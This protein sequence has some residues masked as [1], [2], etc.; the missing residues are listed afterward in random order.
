MPPFDNSVFVPSLLATGGYTQ[1]APLKIWLNQ[2]YATNYW[3]IS[4]LR[5]NPDNIPVKIYT[6]SDKMSSPV[7]QAGD[8]VELEP[9]RDS[10][11]G[12]EYVEWALGF[13]AKHGIDVFVPMRGMAGIAGRVKDF[14]AL[15]TRVLVSP[16]DAVILLDDKDLAYKSARENGIAVPPWRIASNAEEMANAYYDLKT[17]LEDNEM[18]CIKPVQGVGAAGFRTIVNSRPT[19]D[20]LLSKP[21][22]EISLDGLLEILAHTE[23]NGQPVPAFMVLPYLDEPE[24]SVDC[25]SDMDGRI[26]AAIP[27]SKDGSLRKLAT[28]AGKAIDIAV[29]MSETYGLRYLTNT[30]IRWFRGEAVLLETNTRIS[31]GMYASALAGVN[32]PWEGIKLALTGKVDEPFDI[33]LGGTFTNL[34]SVVPMLALA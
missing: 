9:A 27:R 12:T 14:E 22:N 31:G 33:R 4:M 21:R 17:E 32:L 10:V 2:T 3:I 1:S 8:Y 29:A 23:A 13:C 6:T 25:L 26:I 24:V 7:L 34:S 11:T 28:D 19:L 15:G 16:R 18:V 5:D 30:Q 20:D